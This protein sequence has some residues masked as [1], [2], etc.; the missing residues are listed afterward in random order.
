MNSGLRF[1]PACHKRQHGTMPCGHSAGMRLQGLLSAVG[2]T[3]PLYTCCTVPCCLLPLCMYHGRATPHCCLQTPPPP[4]TPQGRVAPAW[5]HRCLLRTTFTPGLRGTRS[6]AGWRGNEQ[7]TT[8]AIRTYRYTRQQLDGIAT[9]P[10]TTCQPRATPPTTTPAFRTRA[11][12]CTRWVAGWYRRLQGQDARRAARAAALNT[13]T[14]GLEPP[15]GRRHPGHS[16]W[17]RTVYR[18]G[19]RMGRLPCTSLPANHHH[20]PSTNI[21]NCLRQT[22]GLHVTIFTFIF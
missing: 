20:L 14:L 21:I 9:T 17:C 2:G 16:A 10:S 18:H 22:A 1:F 6:G 12:A 11:H 13:R 19:T 7:A 3:L 8:I 4:N 15:A 5:F